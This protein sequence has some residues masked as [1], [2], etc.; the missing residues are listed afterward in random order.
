MIRLILLCFVSN[1]SLSPKPNFLR[2]GY[3]DVFPI[4]DQKVYEPGNI[5]GKYHPTLVAEYHNCDPYPAI[6]VNGRISRGLDPGG[7][8]FLDCNDGI[9]QT[10]S[11]MATYE[12]NHVLIYAWFWP[13]AGGK[14]MFFGWGQRYLWLSVVLF[15]KPNFDIPEPLAAAIFN[16]NHYDKMTFV[17][18]VRMNL[19]KTGRRLYYIGEPPGRVHPLI[20]WDDMTQVQRDAL[21]FNFGPHIS[22][23]CPFNNANLN[24]TIQL[25][26]D[27]VIS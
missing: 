2:A 21:E 18:A 9:G 22:Q 23:K 12:G 14:F 11:R 24:H 3:D 4:I 10:Y 15:F 19:R 1:A 17:P 26:F 25:A 7:F 20:D 5:P 27:A 16:T 6:D 8:I 13:R